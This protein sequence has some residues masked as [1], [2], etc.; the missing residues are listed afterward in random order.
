MARPQEPC[1]YEAEDGFDAVAK[2]LSEAK[3]CGA[4]VAKMHDCA[5]GS[6]ADTQL[7][8]IVIKKCEKTFFRNLSPA[9]Q[10][11]YGD[12]MQL[13]A[14]EYSR[15]EGTMYMSAAALCQ[16]NVAADFAA[17]PAA[18]SKPAAAP[19]LTVTKPKH[20]LR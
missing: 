3:S 9:A 1:H 2:D 11:R 19:A 12:E 16:V 6:S 18:A 10:K 20:R 15:Q 7:A 4:A 5:W 13:G 8:P 14:Y 17:N